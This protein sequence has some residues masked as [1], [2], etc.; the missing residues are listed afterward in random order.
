[1]FIFLNTVILVLFEQ[2]RLV[3]SANSI[4]VA[5]LEALKN[6]LRIAKLTGGPKW[7]LEEHHM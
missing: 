3:S 6:H 4:D 1:M 7:T 5:M 2:N